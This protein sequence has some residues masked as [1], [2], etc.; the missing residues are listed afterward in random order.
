MGNKTLCLDF[1]GVINSYVSGWKGETEIPDPPVDGAAEAIE[2]LRVT[3]GIVVYST[4]SRTPAGKA[5]ILAYLDKY[6]IRVDDVPDHKP[7]AVVYLDDRG[8]QFKGD[9]KQAILD[10]ENFKWWLS[11][12]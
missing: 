12:P 7:P 6:G 3:Y 2:R 11:K 5:A 4:R 8:V 9:W 1:D 10:I